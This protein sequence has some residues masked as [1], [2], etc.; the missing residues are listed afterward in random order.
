M[1]N[2]RP[3]ALLLLGPTGSGKT[4][5]GQ[6][7]ELRGLAGRRCVHFDFG[8]N[9]RQV[10][11]RNEPDALVSAEDIVFLRRILQTGAL[12]ED[13]QFPLAAKILRSFLGRHAHGDE[14]WIVLNGLP[15]HAGQALAV[16]EILDVQR[17]VF[18]R[19]S[20]DTVSARIRADA[21]GDRRGR[22]DDDLEI[23]GW[24]LRIFM[25]RTQPLLDFYRRGGV[26]VTTVDVAAATTADAMWEMLQSEMR[27]PRAF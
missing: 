1:P 6:F 4:P 20:A 10:V 15:R 22:I 8:E 13:D 3:S 23:V 12:L 9:L 14:P 7:L 25:E 17:V 26:R 21:G 5:L 24:K 11:A 2:E 18:L 19:C 16:A 27:A